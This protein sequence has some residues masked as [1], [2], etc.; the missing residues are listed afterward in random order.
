MFLTFCLNWFRLGPAPCHPQTLF[1]LIQDP[2]MVPPSPIE[3][4]HTNNRTGWE[5]MEIWSRVYILNF[6]GAL[7]MFITL[8]WLRVN[9]ILPNYAPCHREYINIQTHT[10]KSHCLQDYSSSLFVLFLLGAVSRYHTLFHCLY[11]VEILGYF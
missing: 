8:S 4:E 3:Y 1:R 11:I 10:Q 5:H 7:Q 6:S 2:V 9:Q